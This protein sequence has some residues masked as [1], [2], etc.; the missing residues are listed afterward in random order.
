[1]REPIRHDTLMEKFGWDDQT[2]AAALR[3]GFPRPGDNGT[4]TAHDYV[5]GI[6]LTARWSTYTP[7]VINVWLAIASV[8]RDVAKSDL[9]EIGGARP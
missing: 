9:I 2:Y 4:G 7:A 3:I 6:T 5:G 1:M 8:R